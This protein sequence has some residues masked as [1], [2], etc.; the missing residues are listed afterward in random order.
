MTKLCP[1]YD[2][3]HSFFQ[4]LSNDLTFFFAIF[5][6]I[7]SFSSIKKTNKQFLPIDWLTSCYF[8]LSIILNRWLS[9]NYKFIEWHKSFFFFQKF[10]ERLHKGA[11][12]SIVLLTKSDKFKVKK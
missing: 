11:K 12:T 10:R 3:Y 9:N 7:K 4:L 5:L 6:I 8:Y 1:I 2:T